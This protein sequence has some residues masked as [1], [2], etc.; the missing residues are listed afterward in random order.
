MS[1]SAAKPKGVSARADARMGS[2][3]TTETRELLT[4]LSP[5]QAEEAKAILGSV[6]ETDLPLRTVLNRLFA[7]RGRTNS[8]GL[9]TQA[10]RELRETG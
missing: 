5:Q 6:P 3:L 9:A 8:G 4:R 2:M 10:I 1:H 7:L